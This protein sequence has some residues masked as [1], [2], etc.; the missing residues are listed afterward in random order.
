MSENFLI[1]LCILVSLC[2]LF[3]IMKHQ[4]HFSVDFHFSINLQFLGNWIFE[5][6]RKVVLVFTAVEIKSAA[7]MQLLS[8]AEKFGFTVLK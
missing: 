1:S 7:L 5:R 8:G 2:I 6:K 4:C 3:I